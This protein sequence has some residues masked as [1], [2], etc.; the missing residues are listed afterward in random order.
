MRW[1]HVMSAVIALKAVSILKPSWQL[2]SSIAG[3]PTATLNGNFTHFIPTL[4]IWRSRSQEGEES[5]LPVISVQP[6]HKTTP[7]LEN[8]VS[9]YERCLEILPTCVSRCVRMAIFQLFKES[10][11][12]H[13]RGDWLMSGSWSILGGGRGL[14]KTRT[15]SHLGSCSWTAQ[16]DS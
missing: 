16:V 1:C 5:I 13:W 8:P 10:A 9:V 3:Q 11:D 12:K 2:S 7:W 4:N 6:I 14:D 15:D